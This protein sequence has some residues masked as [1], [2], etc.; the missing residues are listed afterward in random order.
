[1]PAGGVAGSSQ[2]S[3]AAGPCWVAACHVSLPLGISAAQP[4]VCFR[5]S[6][7]S[8]LL[9]VLWFTE[10]QH[11]LHSDRQIYCRH[12]SNSLLCSFRSFPTGCRD[13]TGKFIAIFLPNSATVAVDSCCCRGPLAH[14][15]APH[16]ASSLTSRLLR[17]GGCA[18]GA[19]AEE[20]Q[21]RT[22]QSQHCAATAACSCR[23]MRIDAPLPS[24]PRLTE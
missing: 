6:S 12:Q 19:T 2:A 24:S 14:Q 4:A 16:P 10:G 18:P 13:L 5:A 7:R 17:S 21:A 9:T 8:L 1:M 11:G 23:R 15:A 3:S 22:G 20:E